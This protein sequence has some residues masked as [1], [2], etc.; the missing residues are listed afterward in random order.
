[1]RF[2]KCRNP[3]SE[4]NLQIRNV[5]FRQMASAPPWIVGCSFYLPCPTC[6]HQVY[7]NSTC[8]SI[9][10]NSRTRSS[11]IHYPL[12]PVGQTQSIPAR[13]PQFWCYG[14]V[15]LDGSMLASVI[16]CILGYLAAFLFFTMRCQQQHFPV[17]INKKE[18]KFISWKREA[19]LLSVE[20]QS[21]FS[22]EL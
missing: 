7:L 22:T 18:F 10:S 15:G 2:S 17:V 8:F 3:L 5:C 12:A 13:V 21:I 19:K 4:S 14:H 1:M 11:D 6:P 20:N 16:M 9:C